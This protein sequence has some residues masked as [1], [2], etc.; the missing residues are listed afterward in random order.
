M[1][2]GGV[3]VDM[4]YTQVYCKEDA[5]E[6]L[7]HSD[8]RLQGYAPDKDHDAAACRSPHP[9]WVIAYVPSLMGYKKIWY[10][11]FKCQIPIQMFHGA[12]LLKNVIVYASQ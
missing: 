3:M 4:Q 11:Y 6:V 2:Q 10:E 12:S 5:N 8:Q 1:P 9:P 7:S